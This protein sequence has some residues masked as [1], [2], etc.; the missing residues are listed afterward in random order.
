M[1]EIRACS[2]VGRLYAG[3]TVNRGKKGFGTNIG[4][5]PEKH[6]GG[7]QMNRSSGK[8]MEGPKDRPE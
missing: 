5:M 7:W 6:K 4:P 8:K 3:G 1:G 2:D